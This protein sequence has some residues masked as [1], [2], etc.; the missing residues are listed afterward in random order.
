MNDI[1]PSLRLADDGIDSVLVTLQSI[2]ERA[3]ST[4]L[5]FLV[6]SL[7]LCIPLKACR[8][9]IHV[10]HNS[11]TRLLEIQHAIRQLSYL[12]FIGRS[13]LT[14]QLTRITITLPLAL[15]QALRS[16][17]ATVSGHDPDKPVMLPKHVTLVIRGVDILL[18]RMEQ[19]CKSVGRG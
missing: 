8:I 5:T 4:L 13:R 2:R 3:L 15:E 11:L 6:P 9:C 18:E 16:R 10:L 17:A 12:D 1:S 19:A 14:I 7:Y